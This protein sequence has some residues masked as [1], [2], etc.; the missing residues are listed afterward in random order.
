MA[1]WQKKYDQ[2]A[3]LELDQPVVEKLDKLK[4]VLVLSSTKQ[5]I[6]KEL[7]KELCQLTRMSDKEFEQVR[8]NLLGIAYLRYAMWKKELFIKIKGREL[9]G[10]ELK[11]FARD[12]RV[13][14]FLLKFQGF[15]DKVSSAGQASLW[16][17][18]WS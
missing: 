14:E 3:G 8:G 13:G 11:G 9:Q 4:E 5:V 6:A 16:N 15:N 2:L 18:L 1:L 10:T 7:I 17:S 12:I